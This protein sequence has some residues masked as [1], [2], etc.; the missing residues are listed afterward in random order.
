MS[1]ELADDPI[2]DPCDH[3]EDEEMAWAEDLIESH[4][5]YLRNSEQQIVDQHRH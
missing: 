2:I 5:V 1:V 3:L 4:N